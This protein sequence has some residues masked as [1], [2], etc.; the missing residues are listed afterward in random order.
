MKSGEEK[1]N[2]KPIKAMILGSRLG[3]FIGYPILFIGLI[4]VISEFFKK[5]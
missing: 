1:M 2:I 4:I 5:N 3:G